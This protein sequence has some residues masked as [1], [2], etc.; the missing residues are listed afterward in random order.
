[1]MAEEQRCFYRVVRG[2]GPVPVGATYADGL[3]VQ[4]WMEK[5]AACAES[6]SR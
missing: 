4:V 1:M 6:S 5:L 3:Q 2:L